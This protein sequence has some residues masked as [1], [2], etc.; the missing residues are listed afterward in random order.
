MRRVT[1]TYIHT[2]AAAASDADNFFI[3]EPALV[4]RSGINLGTVH[5]PRIL[6]D[7]TSDAEKPRNRMSPHGCGE[8]TIVPHTPVAKSNASDLAGM[9]AQL[10][11]SSTLVDGQMVIG[12]LATCIGMYLMYYAVFAANTSSVIFTTPTPS[13]FCFLSSLV[14]LISSRKTGPRSDGDRPA[15]KV[16]Y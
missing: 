12:A 9:P 6:R 1:N 16:A 8:P 15:Y 5:T 4:A 13:P 11:A 7:P 2:A 10:A 14:S 3:W